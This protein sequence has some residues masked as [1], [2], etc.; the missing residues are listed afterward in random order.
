MPL[1]PEAHQDLREDTLIE[2]EQVTAF[3][4]G[5]GPFPVAGFV[6]L[7]DMSQA[8]I[9]ERAAVYLRALYEDLEMLDKYP[10]G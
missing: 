2:I 8:E 1:S 7:E 3:I 10:P 9:R 4:E 5:R 6:G